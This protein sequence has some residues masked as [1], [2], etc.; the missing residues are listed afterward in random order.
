MGSKKEVVEDE[1]L[2]NVRIGSMPYAMFQVVYAVK[3]FGVDK[4]IGLNFIP[5][6]Y[7]SSPNAAK[8]LLRNEIDIFG[9][10]LPEFVPF[11]GNAPKLRLFAPLDLFLGF[12][13]VGRKGE[14]K[15]W[16]EL[17]EEMG[18]EKAKEFRLN[19]FKGK[20]FMAIPFRFSLITDAIQQVGLTDK[21]YI[22]KSYAD[23]QLAAVAFIGG[24]G[25]IYTGSLPQQIRLLKDPDNYVHLGGQE[26]LGPMGLWYGNPIT[27]EKFLKENREVILRYL[28]IQYRMAKVW[29]DDPYK[30]APIYNEIL[31]KKTASNNTIE[32][33]IELET[34]YDQFITLEWATEHYFNEKSPYYWKISANYNIQVLVDSGVLDEMVDPDIYM[35]QE[36]LHKELLERK[37]LID[38]INKPLD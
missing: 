22:A 16:P 37:D 30:L 7:V 26:V 28:A 12:I 21:D 10:A 25:D 18:Q 23:D 5:K 11:I 15:P 1:E 29:W 33:Y 3:E 35:P 20:T 38:F 17:L 31:N 9:G 32:Q 24:E 34:V 14:W 4:E 36:E 13:F 19:E 27:T 8:A 6:D 2:I